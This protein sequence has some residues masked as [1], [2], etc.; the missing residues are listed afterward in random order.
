M[1]IHDKI[2]KDLIKNSSSQTKTNYEKY[3]KYVLKFHWLKAD[4]IKQIFK[5]NYQSIKSLD[6]QSQIDLSFKLLKSNFA[7]QKQFAI[8][9]LSKIVNQLDEIFLTNIKPVIDKHMYDWATCDVLSSKVFSNMIK[10][11]KKIAW[12]VK[13]WK[14]DSNLWLQRSA[15]IT[16]VKL[17]RFW[18][19]NDTIIQICKTVI[20]NPER[21]VQL[22][23]WWVLRELS[24][25]DLE[26]TVDFIKNNYKYFS[27]EWLRYSIEKMDMPLRQ[28]LLNYKF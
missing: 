5:E 20:Q 9:I 26:L 28:E 6:K 15:C 19:F 14:D 12:I 3:F 18:E 17:A 21:F 7:E 1:N 8:L 25:A 13:K 16:F 27:R 2:I 24:L 11:D 22:W 4:W 10:E 23:A